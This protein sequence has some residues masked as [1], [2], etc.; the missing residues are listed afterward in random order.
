MEDTNT[1]TGIVA[2]LVAMVVGWISLAAL[3]VTL[4]RNLPRDL[5]GR[6]D[7]VEGR[8]DKLESRLSGVEKRQGELAERM[9]RN[10]GWLEGLREA[11]AGRRTA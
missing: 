7:G 1:L 5:S 4:N 6:I 2:I 10:A 8:M 3:I 11:V 9:V